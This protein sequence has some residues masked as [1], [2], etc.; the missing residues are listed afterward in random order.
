MMVTGNDSIGS[1]RLSGLVV[2]VLLLV[3][4][5][6]VKFLAQAITAIGST[7]AP[8]PA[9]QMTTSLRNQQRQICYYY[10]QLTHAHTKHKNVETHG[11]GQHAASREQ[12]HP[13][14]SQ[15][16]DYPPRYIK[17][18]KSGNEHN[19]RKHCFA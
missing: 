19:I 17:A 5:S 16:K 3:V 11:C 9:S 7:T 13:A 12:L 4:V 1:K 14:T 2:M 18:I 8:S 10:T 6:D 15:G